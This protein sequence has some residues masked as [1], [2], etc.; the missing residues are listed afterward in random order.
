M[1]PDPLRRGARVDADVGDARRVE[2]R[3]HVPPGDGRRPAPA[4]RRRRNRSRGCPRRSARARSGRPADR[5]GV[6]EALDHR[7]QRPAAELAALGIEGEGELGGVGEGPGQPG[8]QA[9]ARHHVE[10]DAGD[11]RDARLARRL[12]LRQHRLEDG[13]LAGDVQVVGAGREAGRDHRRAGVDERAGAVEDGLDAVELG[14]RR[15]RGRRGRR[16]GSEPQLPRQPS[17]RLGVA[18]GEDGR[19]PRRP[20]R[21]PPA[22]PCSRWRRRSSRSWAV[23]PSM[24][25]L[26]LGL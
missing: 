1:L 7:L 4:R 14:G 22:H 15:L 11:E 8:G 9:V 23:P 13:D 12:A 26:F 17:H 25:D 5:A 18:S 19:E 24:S 10:A 16:R 6:G 21:A 3:R 2:R 20:P